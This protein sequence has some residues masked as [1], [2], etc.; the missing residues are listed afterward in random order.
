M[1]IQCVNNP[2]TSICITVPLPEDG[3]ELSV[4]DLLSTFPSTRNK[5]LLKLFPWLE[6]NTFCRLHTMYLARRM[7]GEDCSYVCFYSYSDFYG[8]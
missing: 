3:M 2:Q 6:I 1:P 5:D 8:A 4:G 7:A